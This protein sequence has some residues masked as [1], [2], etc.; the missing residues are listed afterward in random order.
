MA[1][2]MIEAWLNSLRRYDEILH[3]ANAC[4]IL[5]AGADAARRHPVEAGPGARM[6]R[7]DDPWRGR[8]VTVGRTKGGQ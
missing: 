1:P 8:A 3:G 2:V 4:V 7:A 6:R 5:S